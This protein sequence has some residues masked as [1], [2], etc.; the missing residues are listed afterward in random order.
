[1]PVLIALAPVPIVPS[2][3][4]TV[5]TAGHN[6]AASIA[7]TEKPT[8]ISILTPIPCAPGINKQA[9]PIANRIVVIIALSQFFSH[10]L[11]SS[12]GVYVISGVNLS[13][14]FISNPFAAIPKK[15]HLVGVLLS[16][17]PITLALSPTLSISSASIFVPVEGS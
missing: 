1:M 2:P 5:A 7:A 3:S 8:P 9:N 4:K 13:L 6:T 11:F 17:P 12:A 16:S 15:F 10:Q 14:V